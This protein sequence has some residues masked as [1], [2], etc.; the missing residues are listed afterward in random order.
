MRRWPVDVRWYRYPGDLPEKVIPHLVCEL[1]PASGSINWIETRGD[2]TPLGAG[3]VRT[4]LDASPARPTIR[5]A[6]VD[7]VQG[8][9]PDR[10]PGLASARGKT[11]P[12][13]PAV[14]RTQERVE[15]SKETKVGSAVAGHSLADV[16][17]RVRAVRDGSERRKAKVL[18]DRQFDTAQEALARGPETAAQVRKAFETQR[19][20]DAAALYRL[21]LGYSPEE[22]N[23]T[24]PPG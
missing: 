18:L 14:D 24:G 9:E 16:F 13:P 23:R 2:I 20:E 7:Q 4:Y 1:F 3:Q 22:L 17:R 15:P 19:S 8:Y 12:G 11:G 21:L 6:R 5:P 10:P